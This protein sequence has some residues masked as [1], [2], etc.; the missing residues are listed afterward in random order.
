MRGTHST[1]GG[2]GAAEGIIPAHAGNTFVRAGALRRVGDHPRTCGEHMSEQVFYTHATGSSP[3][4]RGTR[5]VTMTSLGNGGIIPAHAGNTYLLTCAQLT[6]GDHPR[7]C[8]EHW[9]SAV[10]VYV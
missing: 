6:P 7:T 10:A 1:L 3:H 8:G 9:L 2:V 4:M 5:S